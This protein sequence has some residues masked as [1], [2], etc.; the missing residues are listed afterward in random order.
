[1][2]LR[3]RT[4]G[5]GYAALSVDHEGL[6][7]CRVDKGD[8]MS[9]DHCHGSWLLRISPPL[10]AAVSLS[11]LH[12]PVML[13]SGWVMVLHR[14]EA[15]FAIPDDGIGWLQLSSSTISVIDDV[16]HLVRV[17]QVLENECAR[18]KVLAWMCLPDHFH[19]TAPSS[20]RYRESCVAPSLSRMVLVPSHLPRYLAL[21][22][23]ILDGI[24]PI[25]LLMNL[26]FKSKYSGKK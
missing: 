21:L 20:T 24:C 10:L 26:N 2:D 16:R 14:R 23:P 1:M 15:S 17:L 5:Y 22:L 6:P 3:V 9:G 4:F 19:S 11:L 12:S 25:S 7:P 18:E 13:Q 8:E